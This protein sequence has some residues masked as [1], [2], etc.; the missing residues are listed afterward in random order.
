M[1]DET[2]PKNELLIKLMGMTG[3][4]SDAEA[5]VAIRKANELL[6]AAGWDW[7]RVLRGKIKVVESPFLGKDNPFARRAPA[8]DPVAAAPVRPRAPQWRPTP[9]PPPPPPPKAAPAPDFHATFARPLS[10][11][12]NKFA[13]FCYCCGKDVPA[14]QG[15]LFDPWNYQRDAQTKWRVA[16]T[17]CNTSGTVRKYPATPIRKRGKASVTD[18]A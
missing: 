16:C 10:T 5:L 15:Y 12:P 6:K 18:L 13:D 3:S 1:R 14:K 17:P 4:S 2:I 7:D 8:V 11:V 9:P